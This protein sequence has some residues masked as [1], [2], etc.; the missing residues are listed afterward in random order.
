[1]K[2]RKPTSPTEA[3]IIRFWKNYAKRLSS[4][5]T[6]K[7]TLE[8]IKLN[9]ST[10]TEEEIEYLIRLIDKA[11]TEINLKFIRQLKG[12]TKIP[13]IDLY[14]I[15]KNKKIY[16]SFVSK[17]NEH[18]KY[19]KKFPKYVKDKITEHLEESKKSVTF[20]AQKLAKSLH[21]TEAM[22]RRHAN[23]IARDQ[24]G[25]FSSAI[26]E[27]QAE[28]VGAKSYIWRTSLDNRVR[29]MHEVREGKKFQYANPPEGGN[30]GMD[31]RCRCTAEAILKI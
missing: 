27:A 5:M 29:H 6:S 20:D 9:D 14:S 30:P 15:T 18:I 4:E 7:V 16:K 23:F 1:M 2:Y 22:S 24:L 31:Y 8:N 3:K 19:F 25:K 13:E 26:N 11:H 21:L 17:R 10:W 12:L 28:Y